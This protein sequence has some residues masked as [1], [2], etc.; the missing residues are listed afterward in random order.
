[1]KFEE[2]VGRWQLWHDKISTMRSLEKSSMTEG[3]EA[4]FYEKCYSV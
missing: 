4:H 2:S 3:N 1:M